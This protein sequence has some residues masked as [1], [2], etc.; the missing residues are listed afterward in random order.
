MMH[1]SA[2]ALAAPEP[3]TSAEE[4]TVSDRRWRGSIFQ[5]VI[6][7]SMFGVSTAVGGAQLATPFSVGTSRGEVSNVYGLADVQF[8]VH[9][10]FTVGIKGYASTQQV[11]RLRG[12]APETVTYTYYYVLIRLGYLARFS[13][14]LALWPNVGIGPAFDYTASFIDMRSGLQVE[15]E[16]PLVFSLSKNVFFAAGPGVQGRT[17]RAVSGVGFGLNVRL[18]LTF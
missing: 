8:H 14:R 3:A 15:G 6:F 10:L 4:Q 11:L 5:Q 7:D 1:V 2:E 17:G 13:D 12:Y 18:G 16:V 9:E